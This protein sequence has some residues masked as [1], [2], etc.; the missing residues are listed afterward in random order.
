MSAYIMSAAEP[1]R[2]EMC[3]VCLELVVVESSERSSAR[4]R[5]GHVF[6]LG[7]EHC[8]NFDLLSCIYLCIYIVP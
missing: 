5:C 6:H 4:L 8:I 1:S 7:N 2:Q 3:T